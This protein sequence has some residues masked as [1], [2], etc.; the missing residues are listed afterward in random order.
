MHGDESIYLWFFPVCTEI[1]DFLHLHP[2]TTAL[3]PEN[4][5]IPRLKTCVFPHTGHLY[6]IEVFKSDIICLPLIYK[7]IFPCIIKKI[8]LRKSA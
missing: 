2:K 6:S 4:E 3:F 1:Y 7:F 5:K 8:L